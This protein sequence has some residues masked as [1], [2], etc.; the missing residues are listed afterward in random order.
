MEGIVV[1]STHKIKV[2]KTVKKGEDNFYSTLDLN[3]KTLNPN[4][5]WKQKCVIDEL[6][7]DQSYVNQ[8]LAFDE[9]VLGLKKKEEV[10]GNVKK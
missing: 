9:N 2:K 8:L 6:S 4:K 10:K 3:V 7:Q 5:K 1:G